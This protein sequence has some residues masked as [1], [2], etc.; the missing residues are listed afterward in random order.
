MH[1]SKG[2]LDD[3]TLRQVAFDVAQALRLLHSTQPPIIHR[4]VKPQKHTAARKR[5]IC[6]D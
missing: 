5:S 6:V 2:P 1:R 3:E 4:D